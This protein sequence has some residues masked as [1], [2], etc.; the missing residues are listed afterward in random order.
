ML[1][2]FELRFCGAHQHRTRFEI[3]IPP[4]PKTHLDYQFPLGTIIS[5][6]E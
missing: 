2:E 3:E 5:L 4:D 1:R 6:I